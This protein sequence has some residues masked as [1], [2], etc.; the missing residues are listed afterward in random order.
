[1]KK[2]IV[3]VGTSLFENYMEDSSVAQNVKGNINDVKGGKGSP[4]R[5]ESYE[6]YK[7][8][9]QLIKGAVG[10]WANGNENENASAEI[11]SLIK[12]NKKFNDKIEAHLICT[13]T[14][15]SVVAAE[16]I[17]DWF[18]QAPGEVNVIYNKDEREHI[19]DLQVSNYGDLMEKG[20]KNLINKI[21]NITVGCRKEDL[22]F[23][24]TGGYKAIIPY[25]TFMAAIHECRIFYIFEDNDNLIEIPPLPLKKDYEFF[26]KHWDKMEALKLIDKNYTA[27]KYKELEEKGLV[28][29]I[30]HNSAGLSA[31]G[32]MFYNDIVQIPYQ[33][34]IPDD[35]WSEIQ[36]QPNILNIIKNKLKLAIAGRSSKIQKKAGHLVYDDGNN[37]YR[38]FYFQKG[39]KTYI[40]KTFSVH[41]QY[42]QFLRDNPNGTNKDD[43]E[44][45]SK[46]Q[47]LNV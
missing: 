16:I 41:N 27:G 38:I 40:Y 31:L 28:L 25:L 15:L 5:V 21:E 30:D 34:Y 3:T 17:Q 7:T 10:R 2:V 9:I 1:M 4:N 29:K 11:K 23:N 35:V 37:P 43:I 45:V 39:D 19:E 47:V 44:R 8:E 6:T 18:N 46:L 12:I 33:L 42:E 14:I 32:D 13:D 36:Q 26:E 24:I 22:L 20:L